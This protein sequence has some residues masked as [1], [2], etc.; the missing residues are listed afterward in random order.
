LEDNWLRDEVLKE[1]HIQKNK[2][3]EEYDEDEEVAD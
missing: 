2:Q 1:K 3:D